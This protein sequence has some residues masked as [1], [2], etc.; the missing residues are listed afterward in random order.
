MNASADTDVTPRAG[1]SAERRR[2]KPWGLL[3][4]I[5]LAFALG[6]AASLAWAATGPLRLVDRV[7]G[8]VS[9]VNVS[10]AAIC[11]EPDGGG[12]QRCS[13]VYQRPDTARLEVGGRVIVAV[14]VLRTGP[15]REEEI[16]VRMAS[17]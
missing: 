14:G 9:V 16:F 10:G 2:T 7:S 17:E 1:V 4:V 15:D 12:P 11:L 3:L 13:V 6:W 5:A 8:I